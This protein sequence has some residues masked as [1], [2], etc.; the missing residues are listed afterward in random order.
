MYGVRNV[1][2]EIE[3]KVTSTVLITNW[4]DVLQCVRAV[5]LD[6]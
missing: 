4:T 5:S 6:C 2:G 1:L 3:V